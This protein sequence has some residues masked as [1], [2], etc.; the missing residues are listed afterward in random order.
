MDMDA[1]VGPGHGVCSNPVDPT[2]HSSWVGI[3]DYEEEAVLLAQHCATAVAM[4]AANVRSRL[5]F[6]GGDTREKAG[7]V[8]EAESYFDMARVAGWWNAP[9]VERRTLREQHA[10]DSRDNLVFSLACFYAAVGAFPERLVVVGFEFKRIRY[11]QHAEALQWR[12]EFCY[13]GINNPPPG[14]PLEA[15][16]AGEKRKRDAMRED[17]LLLGPEWVEQR[18]RRNPFGTVEPYSASVPMLAPF[19]RYLA[20]SGAK[21][22]APWS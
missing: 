21:V 16:L 2:R 1:I 22:P 15:A 5:I 17:P 18:R 13:I 11:Y 6:S 14:G 12:G 20:G 3:Y 10:R 8:S 9:E 4:A 19:L 7:R